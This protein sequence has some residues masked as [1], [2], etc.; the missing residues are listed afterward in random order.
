MVETVHREPGAP[1]GSQL[2]LTMNPRTAVTPVLAAAA[3]AALAWAPGGAAAPVPVPALAIT[4]PQG[5]TI[6]FATPTVLS[7]QGQ[8][9]NL[10]NADTVGH[11]VTSKATKPKRVKFGKKW[12]TIRIPLFTSGT[13]SPAGVGEVKGV[14]GL[15]PGK[16]DFYCSA[17]TG[18][19]GQLTVNA[20]A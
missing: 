15:K 9:L 13:V 11:D 18:M 6:G 7:L 5:A 19:R 8:A 2:E 1:T 14:T 12:Y 17:H 16:Y 20:G 4:G 10:L 3:A